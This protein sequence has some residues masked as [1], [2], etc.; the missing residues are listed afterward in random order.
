ME[1]EF[2]RATPAHEDFQFLIKYLDE[3]LGNRY[4]KRK[5]IT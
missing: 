3:D 1:F 5:R 2:K 4:E